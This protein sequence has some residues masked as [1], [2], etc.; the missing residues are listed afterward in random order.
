MSTGHTMIS[1]FEDKVQEE[2]GRYYHP[3]F[4]INKKVRGC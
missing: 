2:R 1:Q 4:F 3:K